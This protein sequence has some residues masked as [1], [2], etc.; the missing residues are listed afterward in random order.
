MAPTR[1]H[2]GPAS[3]VALLNKWGSLVTLSNKAKDRWFPSHD[4]GWLV[5]RL[6]I[7]L[8]KIITFYIGKNNEF[9]VHEIWRKV[10]KLEKVHKF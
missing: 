10:H 3:M 5:D 9:K 4:H 1:R 6:I 7:D 2:S 8:E